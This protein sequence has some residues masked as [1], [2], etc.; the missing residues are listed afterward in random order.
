MGEQAYQLS[1]TAQEIDETL[2]NMSAKLT[3]I[4]FANLTA[5]KFTETVNG[6]VIEHTIEFDDQGRPIKIDDITITWE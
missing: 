5:N 1:M 2:Q 4:N 3:Q 6:E